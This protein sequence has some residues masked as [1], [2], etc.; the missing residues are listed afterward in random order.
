[1]KTNIHNSLI[2]TPTPRIAQEIGENEGTAGGRSDSA[3]ENKN[4]LFVFIQ[5]PLSATSLRRG[6]IVL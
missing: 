5:L 3:A 1:M 4:F 2:F 6:G